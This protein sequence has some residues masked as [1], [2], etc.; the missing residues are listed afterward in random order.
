MIYSQYEL[1]LKGVSAPFHGD[2]W[3]RKVLVKKREEVINGGWGV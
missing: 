2:V 1:S 3:G